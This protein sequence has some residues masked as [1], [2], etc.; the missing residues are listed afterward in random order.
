M[1]DAAWA[2]HCRCPSGPVQDRLDSTHVH[3]C[4]VTALS[5]CSSGARA[6]A[7]C[8]RKLHCLLTAHLSPAL[9]YG[10]GHGHP[11]PASLR[12][13]QQLLAYCTSRIVSCRWPT[14]SGST[15]H[16]I[17]GAGCCCLQHQHQVGVTARSPCIAWCGPSSY[18]QAG[19]GADLVDQHNRLAVPGAACSSITTQPA[20]GT[21]APVMARKEGAQLI[22]AHPIQ[23]SL[24]AVLALSGAPMA[25]CS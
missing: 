23:C 6:A 13:Q 15:T 19:A 12:V 24:Q 9:R 14:A 4:A 16:S 17:S 5:R 7:Y 2:K 11:P 22:A 1:Q 21:A 10:H 18:A 20:A 8:H 3:V 25:L